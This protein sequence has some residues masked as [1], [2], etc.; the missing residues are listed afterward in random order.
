MWLVLFAMKSCNRGKI[1]PPTTMVINNPDAAS[2]YFPKPSTE[3]L[4]IPPHIT[5]MNSP[6]ATRKKHLMGIGLFLKLIAMDSG[7]NIAA[8][9]SKIAVKDTIIICRRVEIFPL[10]ALLHAR[11]IIIIPQYAAA[12]EPP[13]M[14]DQTNPISLI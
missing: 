8:K 9:M 7:K 6:T 14:A 13:T 10:I 2:V 3:R 5:D 1:P 12:N 11:P 4:K